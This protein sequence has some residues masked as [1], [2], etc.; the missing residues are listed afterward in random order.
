MIG[1]RF[2]RLVVLS[3]SL[4]A[5]KRHKKWA[6]VCDCGTHKSVRG[7]HLKSGASQSCGCL[8]VEISTQRLTTHNLSYSPTHVSWASMKQRCSSSKGMGW[9]NYASKGITVCD[10]WMSFENFLSDMGVRPSKAHSIDRIDG[11][12]GYNKD[13]CRWATAKEQSRNRNIIVLLTHQG[14]TQRMVE[15]AEQ[16]GISAVTI[17]ARIQR[18]GWSVERA[19]TEPLRV[20]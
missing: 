6:C 15:W 8:S 16:I 3:L 18:Y 11:A 19:L 2:G 4:E 9:K 12:K 10:R 13:N 20:W 14:K 5:G 17:R 7:S 1:L